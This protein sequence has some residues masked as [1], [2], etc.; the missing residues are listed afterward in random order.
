MEKVAHPG[1]AIGEGIGHLIESEIAKILS[2]ICSKNGYILALKAKDGGKLLVQDKWK[3]KFN[4]DMVITDSKN[5]PIIILESKYLR[6]KKH[7]RDKGSWICT[8]HSNLRKTFPTI[9]SSIAILVGDWTEGAK[10]LMHSANITYLLIPFSHLVSVLL[11]YGIDFAW[12]EK[13]RRKAELAWEQF[14]KLT[15]KQKENLQKELV[16]VIEADLQRLIESILN[17]TKLEKIK[18]VELTISGTTGA[19]YVFDFNNAED[20]IS[21]CKTSDFSNLTNLINKKKNNN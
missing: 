5:Q 14:C 19:T 4:L 7:M 18:S 1:S 11:K 6:Y 15:P 21:F 16:K 9:R 17:E 13:D 3:N 12:N 2:G 20:L 8:A 10:N